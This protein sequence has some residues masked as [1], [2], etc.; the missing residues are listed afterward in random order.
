M[1]D[2]GNPGPALF[3]L[4]SLADFGDAEGLQANAGAAMRL[5]LEAAGSHDGPVVLD[6]PL[7]TYH[8]YPEHAV[9]AAY[10]I[11][12]T[13]SEE[14]NQDVTKT[15]ALLLKG[16]RRLTLEGNGSLF[17][18]HGKQTMLLLDGCADIEI[19]NL[20]F[21]YA[22]PTVTEMTVERRGEHELDVCVHPDSHYELEDGR[23]TWVGEGWRLREGPVQHCD[24]VQN[25]TW[26]ME[27]WPSRAER[28]EEIGSRRLRFHFG[29]EPVPHVSPGMTVQMRD[30]V[31]DQVGVLILECE[32]IRLIG[33]GLHFM[34]GLGIVGQFSAD[35]TFADLDVTPRPETGRTVAGFA[36]FIHCSGCRGRVS[37]TDS[38]FAGAHDDAVNVHG[39]YLRI[40]GQP[41]PDQV[42]VRFMH[43]QTYGFR[44]FFPG[45]EIA[46][47]DARSLASY[48]FGRIATVKMFDPRELLLT[49]EQPA[50]ASIGDYDVIENVTWT[51]EVLIARNH[52]ARI[53]T[54]GILV[55]SLRKTVIEGNRFERMNM[56]AVL[57]AGDANSWYESGAVTDVRI[58]GN[59]FIDCGGEEHPVIRI[60]PEN[61]SSV[62]EVPDVPVHRNI[63]IEDNR[64][65]TAHAMLLSARS[66]E[67]L[68]FCRNDILLA[69]KA[70]SKDGLYSGGV[71]HRQYPDGLFK[72]ERC[73]GV[74]M[75]DNSVGFMVAP[76]DE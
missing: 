59:Q 20:H 63:R 60:A 16:L 56:S 1:T 50:P 6:I 26:R 74:T 37:I 19:R 55:S 71:F 61:E 29:E 58:S 48:A 10:H 53:P 28:I 68:A 2:S 45:D 62:L 65:R 73:S 52:F 15:V 34:H 13:A 70:G 66:T 64:F 18:I 42:R 17:V 43:P 41:A 22:V 9:R 31:R 72:L 21:D 39:T 51:P 49:L 67:G 12:N 75:A 32:R 76:T 25:A 54:R 4:I 47:V 24:L 23:L 5:A 33:M 3:K 35:L 11:T 40:V 27:D 36:D 7:G 38:R 57:V 8:F 46:F 14:E 44:A 30:G 69:V